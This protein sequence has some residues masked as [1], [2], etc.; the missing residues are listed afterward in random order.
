MIEPFLP[1]LVLSAFVGLSAG[2]IGSLI[3]LKRMALVGD[4]LSHVA[5]PGLAIG[6]LLN[7][8]PFLGA[9]AFLFASVVLTWHLERVARLTT[10]SIIG[11]LFVTALAIGILI[12]PQEELLEALFGD[13][14][15]ITLVG[16]TLAI[17]VSVAVTY[18][19]KVT[20]NQ[21]VLTLI[22]EELAV[23]KGVNVIRVN[24]IYLLLVSLVVA[25]GVSV[26]GTLLVGALVVIPAVSAKSISSNLSKYAIFSAVFGVM[27]ASLGVI[28]ASYTNLPAGPLSV[29]FGMMIFLT[30]LT[31][32]KFVFK[33]T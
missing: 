20:Y 19:M 32:G 30:C 26:V 28:S 2:Y 13:I 6:V 3:V 10:E 21:V 4:A 9:F 8:D 24:L 18:V 27:S 25:V 29:L 22:S 23:S 14:S 31:A 17:I 5:L 33:R 7:F 16:A 15:R 1:S 12:M 11:V